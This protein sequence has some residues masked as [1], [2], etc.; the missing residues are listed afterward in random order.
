[1]KH[2]LFR[3][4][5]KNRRI[6]KIKSK[7][8]H[9]IKKREKDRE[10][11]KLLDYLDQIDPQAAQVYREKEEQKKVE[12][13]LRQRHSSN[14]KFAKKLKRFGMMENDNIREQFNEMMR[15]KN[16]LKQRTKKVNQ[17]V[18]GGSSD[19][20]EMDSDYEDDGEDARD[21][22]IKDIEGEIEDSE[23]DDDMSSDELE[24]D[25]SEAMRMRFDEKSKNNRKGLQD[26]KEKGIMGLKFMKR[27][28]EKQKE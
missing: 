7:L 9:K 14:N 16:T 1:M 15:E 18:E 23:E 10:E 20:S 11:K 2:L 12:E 27:G 24:S 4:E 26:S 13:R 19:D 28:E 22:A 21:K 5:M 6:A 3:Q 17:L 25:D 8:Y